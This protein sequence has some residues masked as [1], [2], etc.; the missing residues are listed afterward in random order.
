MHDSKDIPKRKYLKTIYEIQKSFGSQF[1]TISRNFSFGIKP[2]D[3]QRV[4]L[5]TWF[6]QVNEAKK[7]LY[8]EIYD[9]FQQ[10]PFAYLGSTFNYGTF[11][12]GNVS[13]NR[14]KVNKN[15]I[16]WEP[17][18]EGFSMEISGSIRSFIT[19][20]RR[21]FDENIAEIEGIKR[22]IADNTEKLT[23]TVI[24]A[25]DEINEIIKNVEA[26]TY[27]EITVSAQSLEDYESLLFSLN[28][29][30]SEYNYEANQVNSAHKS[31][32]S[33]L[34]T[35]SRLPVFPGITEKQAYELADI[36]AKLKEVSRTPIESAAIISFLQKV[37]KRLE[38]KRKSR[39]KRFEDRLTA[40]LYKK[41]GNT[42]ENDKKAISDFTRFL[43][44]HILKLETHVKQKLYDGASQN[45]YFEMI[46]F[47]ARL[48]QP[49]TAVEIN[50]VLSQI[51][52]Y[53]LQGKTQ[54]EIITIPGFSWDKNI[55]GKP[56]KLTALGFIEKQLYLCMASSYKA[57]SI[58][59]EN[60]T[61]RFV[62][63]TGGQKKKNS[64]PKTIEY[65]RG[66][67]QEEVENDTPLLLPLHFGKSYARRYLFNKQW[68]LF[69]KT[70]Q[71]FLNNARV[72]REK[73]N[74]GDPWKHYLDVSMSGEKV[75]GYKDFA[76]DILTKAECVIGI[77]RGEVIPIAF[78][79]LRLRDK[80]VLEKGFLA[81]SYI[82]KLKSYDSIKREYQSRGR[83]IPKYLKSKV[84]RLQK[85][86]LETAASEILYLVA[87]YKAVVIL[88]NLNDRFS[89]VEK[90]LIPKKTYKKIEK[91]LTDSL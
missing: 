1:G 39:K 34:D 70:P 3:Q 14:I 66:S 6:T 48:A 55:R 57:F 16:K 15:L 59:N 62:K 18:I 44:N 47:R 65:V 26:K 10:K 40:F 84:T 56:L 67:F 58:D 83:S 38:L 69:S 32:L 13:F 20:H 91:L 78:T 51:K 77:D 2:T 72:K 73:V 23:S 17:V 33:M 53:F 81:T 85:T 37:Q 5:E 79:V 89:G 90:S 22:R 52:G 9:D 4:K 46:A 42:L 41:Y 45:K 61:L 8:R 87:K 25:D 88:E 82:E 60:S 74:P 29:V 54:R 68:G 27:E 12:K 30:I 50:T 11:F 76:H 7:Q 21:I 31:G 35:L 28:E 64:Q 86:L 19:N 24:V 71:I 63:T 36:L 49:E 80:K 43:D 75:F